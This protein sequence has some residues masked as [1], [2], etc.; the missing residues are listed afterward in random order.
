M[1][2]ASAT[3]LL[4]T[5]SGDVTAPAGAVHVSVVDV[6]SLG[7][8]GLSLRL[9]EIGRAE[10]RLAALKAHVLAE[11]GRRH[12]NAVAQRV[13]RD[14]LRS[15]KSEAKRDVE[16]AVQ[17]AQLPATSEALESGEIP[18]GHA[19]LIARASSESSIDEALLVEAA[20]EQPLD[21]FA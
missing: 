4:G 19:R 12:S 9:R 21:E 14:E 10:S 8:E 6:G 20:N 2:F 1:E 3:D 15:S 5:T 16:S 17:L 11:V 18:Q 7:D 13:A